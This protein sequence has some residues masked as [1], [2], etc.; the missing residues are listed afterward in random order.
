MPSQNLL[1]GM[2]ENLSGE[3]VREGLDGD[4]RGSRLIEPRFSSQT[5]DKLVSSD[6]KGWVESVI[7]ERLATFFEENPAVAKAY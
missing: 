6:V 4:H 3:D 5:K 7:N 1:K 2:K